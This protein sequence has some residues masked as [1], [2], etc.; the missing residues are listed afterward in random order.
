M[1]VLVT[2]GTGAFGMAVCQQLARAG[3]DPIA[4]A[5]H[6][7]ARL[8]SGVRFVAGDVRDPA[9]V[10]RAVTGC[11]AVVHLAWFMGVGA[12]AAETY[13]VNIGGTT[14]LLDAMGRARCRRLVFTSSTTSYGCS[15]HH[16]QPFR[17]DE[18]LRPPTSFVYAAQKQTIE[19]LIGS[20]DVDAVVARVTVVMGRSVDNG[21]SQAYAGPTL[22]DIG[23]RSVVQVVHQ[24]DVGRF[25][26]QAALGSWRGTVNLAAP[27]SVSMKRAGELLGRRVLRVPLSA[28]MRSAGVI[29]KLGFHGIDAD[30]A[31]ALAFWPVVDTNELVERWGFR[32]V[33]GQEDI[34]RDQA[35]SAS[36][37]TYLLP[38]TR[39][40]PHRRRLPWAEPHPPDPTE[41]R[42]DSEWR[43]AAPEGVRGSLDTKVDPAYPLFSATNLQEA[44]PGPLTP[45]S[46]G[47]AVHGLGAATDALVR[48]F[49]L[50][51]EV[52]DL[53]RIGLAS[54][55]HRVYVNVSSVRLMAEVVPGATVEDVD[56][57]Y[58][59]IEAPPAKKPRPTAREAL[60]AARLGA[61]V[62]PRVAGFRAEVDR[63]VAGAAAITAVHPE[64]L[65]DPALLAHL[66]LVHDM[67]C[68]AW[69]TSSTGN[70]L[71]SGVAS[72]LDVDNRAG[73]AGAAALRGVEALA[74][75]VQA[76][77][78]LRASLGDRPVTREA[79]Q[80]LRDRFPRFG[81]AVDEL[82]RT[83][84]H[85]G[86]GETELANPVFA[87]RPELLVDVVRR[88]A[89][90]SSPRPAHGSSTSRR[91]PVARLARNLLENKER[92]RDA[93]VRLIHAFRIAV[94]ERARRLVEDGSLAAV[95]DVFYLTYDELLAHGPPHQSLLDA[96]RAE[97]DRLAG[98][99]MPLTFEGTW[100]PHEVA[101][102]PAAVGEIL[103]G[104]AAVAGRYE[105]RVRV[106]YEPT[107]TLEADEVLVTATTD[108]GWTPYFALAGAVVTD[109]GGV[110]SHAAIVAREHAIPSVVGTGDAT[111]RLLTGMNVRV[112][113]TAGTVEVLDVG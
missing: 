56:R 51:G 72:A 110:A 16:P 31:R 28:A 81:R 19:E 46:L 102:R 38:G 113:G 77:P 45:L 75:H 68:Q 43:H 47:L 8:P 49:G 95:E 65:S 108:I 91:G 62:A 78:E 71:L 24:E 34:L 70:F 50:E 41:L 107:D 21:P 86:P 44:F 63:L 105:G 66:G 14:N 97:R 20:H 26:E 39:Q 48:V 82:V 11:D 54:F 25:L 3:A 90:S 5:R 80:E 73:S 4:M 109:V 89:A 29:N 111:S 32:P 94:R 1:K 87:D 69:A 30:V 6:E 35:R 22:L 101:A 61:R 13:A 18:P 76:D 79:L 10:E 106:M 96:R 15:E 40:R 93:G 57:M 67:V 92:A 100:S 103:R 27:G 33:W 9:A 17:E 23:G 64:Q 85:R 36:R 37:S 98:Y 58:L 53:L 83:C 60:A 2:G 7:P 52:A 59:G 88:R 84:G 99:E 104:V 12:P 42:P 112:D 74:R 55:G